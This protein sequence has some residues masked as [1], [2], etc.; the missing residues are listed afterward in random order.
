MK[1]GMRMLLLTSRGSD[2]R[3]DDSRTSNRYENERYNHYGDERMRMDDRQYRM[4]DDEDRMMDIERG[5]YIEDRFRDRRG[6]EHYDNGRY[7][8]KSYADMHHE[9]PY[10][11][12]IY[13]HEEYDNVN[14][15]R[16]DGGRY[17][18][19]RSRTEYHEEN[20]P[21]MRRIG[22]NANEER[23]PE[24]EHSYRSYNEYHPVN[25]GEWRRGEEPQH[26]HGKGSGEPQFDE[27]MATEWAEGLKNED[28]SKGP[29]W[30]FEQ[31]KQMQSQKGIDCDPWEFYAAMNMLYSDY[32][33]VAK[34]FGTSNVDFFVEMTKAFLHD[35]DAPK[36]KLALYYECIVRH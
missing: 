31:T 32:G 30:T 17:R 27:E 29:H 26:G 6:R 24:M 10:I 34:K 28:G 22:F 21:S 35:K 3:N 7:A 5:M 12:P 23:R 20:R 9:K 19:R 1:P 18:D 13:D 15:R 14:Y 11:P 8:P 36:N 33:K 2:R 16:G 4:N 25:E